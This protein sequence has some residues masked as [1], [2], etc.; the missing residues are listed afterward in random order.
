VDHAVLDER[1]LQR[2]KLFDGGPA[3]HTL[4]CGYDVCGGLVVS[5]DGHDLIDEGA[6]V[7]RGGRPFVGLDR[8]FVKLGAREPPLLGDHLRR[9]TLVEGEIVIAGKDF[10]AIGHAG[11]PGRTERNAAHHLDAAGDDDILLTRHHR[12][13]REV[14]RLLAGTACA[15]DRGPGDALRPA[16][17]EDRVAPDVAGLI[18]DL[19][20]AS[21]DHVVDNLGT[22]TGAFQQFVEDDGGQVGGVHPGQPTVALPYCGAYRLGNDRLTHTSAPMALDLFES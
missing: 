11:C 21:P 8:V 5:E 13:H 18:A 4:V 15:V 16:G 7:L 12:L 17:G 10:R 3:P 9:Q 2:R 14:E 22:D 6:A 20:H 19:R 1:G